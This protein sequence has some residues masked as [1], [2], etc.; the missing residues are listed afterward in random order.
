[1]LERTPWR[2]ALSPEERRTLISLIHK[3]APPLSATDP[4]DCPDEEVTS[5]LAVAATPPVG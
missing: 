4:A 2:Q 1:M 3:M 5:F